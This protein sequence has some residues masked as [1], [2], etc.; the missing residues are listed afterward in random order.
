MIIPGNLLITTSRNQTKTIATP[1]TVYN[2]HN[3]L[4]NIVFLIIVFTNKCDNSI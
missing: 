2:E 3:S 4:L 1:I